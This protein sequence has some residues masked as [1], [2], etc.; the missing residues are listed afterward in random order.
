MAAR[1]T[2]GQRSPTPGDTPPVLEAA[3]HGLDAGP[4]L[5][6][7]PVVRDGFVAGL[8]SGDAGLEALVLQGVPKP[9]GVVALVGQ[10]PV[11]LWQ[12]AQGGQSAG[13]VAGLAWH[14]G[15]PG[16]GV[17]SA[18]HGGPPGVQPAPWRAR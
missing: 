18:G 17:L 8:A 9:A 13:G 5:A 15:R 10:E 12:A 3:D 1:S 14:S 11:G 16:S 4:S 7:A 2:L 6:A